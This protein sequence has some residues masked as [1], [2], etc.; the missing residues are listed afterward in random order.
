MPEHRR[1]PHRPVD[2]TGGATAPPRFPERAE[3][4]P[5][6]R[7]VWAG[8]LGLLGAVLLTEWAQLWLGLG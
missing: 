4:R 5:P 3:P 7:A 6:A 2:P 8:I 1:H